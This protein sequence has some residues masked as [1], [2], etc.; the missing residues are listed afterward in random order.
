[1]KRKKS[2][3]KQRLNILVRIPI[4]IGYLLLKLL[5]ILFLILIWIP[6]SLSAIIFLINPDNWKLLKFLINFIGD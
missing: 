1:M 3:I 5:A 6:I 2:K 4:M